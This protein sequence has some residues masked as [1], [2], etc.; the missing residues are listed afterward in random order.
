[1]QKNGKKITSGF[2]N[3][4]MQGTC[5]IPTKSPQNLIPER[6]CHAGNFREKFQEKN[7]FDP[8]EILPC[9]IRI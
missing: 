3:L 5:S 7:P 4:K 2:K 9:R 8:G 6:S 1:M